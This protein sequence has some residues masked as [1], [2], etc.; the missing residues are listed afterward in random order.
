MKNDILLEKWD[1]GAEQNARGGFSFNTEALG[2]RDF[3]IPWQLN[4]IWCIRQVC[5]FYSK[6]VCEIASLECIKES[7]GGCP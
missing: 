4:V 1:Y 6:A 2:H 3:V 7:E 5:K